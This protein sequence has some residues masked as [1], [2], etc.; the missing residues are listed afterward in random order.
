MT[1]KDR[2]AYWKLVGSRIRHA[3]RYGVGITQ[4]QL[5]KCIHLTRTSIVNIEAGRQ[6]VLADDLFDLGRV[7]GVS[8][9]SLMPPM[10]GKVIRVVR[11]DR[12]NRRLVEK[13]IGDVKRLEK[14]INERAH[15]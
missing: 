8:V 2:D 1:K 13:I 9:D 10:N 4:E 12:T 5:A 15:S 7:L 6:R 11:V 14:R 3:R